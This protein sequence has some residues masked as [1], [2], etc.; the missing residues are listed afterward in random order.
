MRKMEQ[1]PHRP[2]QRPNTSDALTPRE[3]NEVVHE[4]AWSTC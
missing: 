1:R 4:M 3:I 2:G